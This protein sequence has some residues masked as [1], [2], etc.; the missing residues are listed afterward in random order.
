[1]GP[2][3]GLDLGSISPEDVA[4]ITASLTATEGNE[5]GDEDEGEGEGDATD[6]ADS[7][8]IEIT[9]SASDK[10][11]EPPPTPSSTYMRGAAPPPAP[12]FP[13]VIWVDSHLQSSPE[14][15]SEDAAAILRLAPGVQI[16][17]FASVAGLEHFLQCH[18]DL[19]CEHADEVRVITNV[20]G[21]FSPA[22]Y[23]QHRMS[24]GDAAEGGEAVAGAAEEEKE[25]EDEDND[26]P[27][28]WSLF[29]HD[30]E[31]PA[32]RTVD[33][34]VYTSSKMYK[35]PLGFTA[36]ADSMMLDG[37]LDPNVC[38]TASSAGCVSFASFSNT[39]RLH[40]RTKSR[41]VRCKSESKDG[42]K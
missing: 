20:Y 10:N 4:A 21:V 6:V 22:Q 5:D 8:D 18:H 19:I 26:T 16:V 12:H 27:T 2:C 28:V 35:D 14:W 30:V 23:R 1:M 40:S 37:T 33:F 11:R 24:R 34:M 17:E 32:L 41:S 15:N 42:A 39:A 25:E 36:V 29:R 7:G 9:L 3:V 31:H 13:L 38:I